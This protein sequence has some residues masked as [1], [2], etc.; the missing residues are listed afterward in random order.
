MAAVAVGLLSLWEEAA[1]DLAGGVRWLAWLALGAS[2]LL[3]WAQA[4]FVGPVWAG[5]MYL[6]LIITLALAGRYAAPRMSQEVNVVIT[7]GLSLAA[8]V[9]ALLGY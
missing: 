2:P 5:G 7:G 3:Q 9:M 6:F 1:H 4:P 8:L